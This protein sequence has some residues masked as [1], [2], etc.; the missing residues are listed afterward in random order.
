MK[1]QFFIKEWKTLPIATKVSNPNHTPTQPKQLQ[2]TTM[3]TIT[4]HISQTISKLIMKHECKQKHQ[5]GITSLAYTEQD[6]SQAS[7]WELGDDYLRKCLQ[8][9]QQQPPWK[10][11]LIFTSIS[12]FLILPCVYSLYIWETFQCIELL[13]KYMDSQ[14]QVHRE[15]IVK[16]EFNKPK[17]VKSPF[18]FHKPHKLIRCNLEHVNELWT[19][20]L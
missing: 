10:N 7:R 14:V 4:Q 19:F 6:T 5:N 12:S 2:L 11:A 17:G 9:Y 13:W 20:L 8:S 1:A 3:L 15:T 18:I 16:V